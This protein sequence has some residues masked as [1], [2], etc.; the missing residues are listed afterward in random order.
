[1]RVLITGSSGFV[2]RHLIR[3]LQQA[4]TWKLY[5]LSRHPSTAEHIEFIHADLLDL[6]TVKKA[7]GT[8]RPDIIFHLAGQASVADSFHDPA[9]TLQ[10]N[11]FGQLHLL[12]AV[13]STRLDPLI[14]VVG[15]N[16][17]YGMIH[18]ED[19]PIDEETPL[20]PANPY[21]VSKAAQDMLALQ[22][23]LSY[24]LRIVRMRPF[25]HIG[26]GQDERFVVPGLA[27]QIALI[28]AGMQ[29]PVLRVGNLEAR[30]DFTDV[31]DIVRAYHLA[32]LHGVPGEVYNL[33]SGQPLAIRQ[34]L[35]IMLEQSSVQIE[36]VVDPERVRPVDVPLVVCD[37]SRF[38]HHTGWQPEIPIRQTLA[39][40]L[41][42][43]RR[44]VARS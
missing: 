31:R 37:A 18:P 8:I 42:E 1:M 24:S 13:R 27:R 2:G 17:V 44:S 12:E 32:A 6:A 25:N 9:A 23:H 38:R 30:R 29:E 3:H 26:P 28:E 7:V 36:I 16:E 33:G 11:I 5:G 22:Y 40:V 10:N 19:L 14:V 15:S 41:A 4:T 43:W 35:E 21:A 20:R 39:D 34:L